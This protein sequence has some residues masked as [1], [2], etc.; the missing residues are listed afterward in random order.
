MLTIVIEERSGFD[1]DREPLTLG[2]P[3]PRGVLFHDSHLRLNDPYGPSLPAQT[4][5]LDRWSDQSCRWVLLDFQASVLAN[6]RIACGLAWNS[7]VLR[8]RVTPE[9]RV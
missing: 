7:E 1:R 5:V 6:Q 4:R 3:F 8:T 9:V 2:V